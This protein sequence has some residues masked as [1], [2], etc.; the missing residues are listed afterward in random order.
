MVEV[1]FTPTAEDYV[2]VQRAMFVR[3]LRSRR[4]A[5]RMAVL[6]GIVVAASLL[7]LLATGERPSTALLIAIGGAAGGVAALAV[8]IGI[9]RLLLPRRSRRLFAQQRTLH[10]EHRTVLDATGFRQH[11]V[12]A[13]IALPWGELLRWHVGRD[14]LLLYSN[15]MLAYFIPVRAFGIGQLAQVEAILTQAGLPRR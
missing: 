3:S 4:F 15:D 12:R 6:V 8:C 14:V 5:G 11:S 7:L 1:M 9:N 2:A 10:H 13:D